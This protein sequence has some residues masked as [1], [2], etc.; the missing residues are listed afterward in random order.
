[1]SNDFVAD[2]DYFADKD[3]NLVEANDPK[4]ATKIVSQGGSLSAEEAAKYGLSNE[5]S[6]GE[7]SSIEV[8]S[9]APEETEEEAAEPKAKARKSKASKKGK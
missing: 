5:A 3:G 4:R 2:K 1:M 6:G 9:V 8:A 7:E